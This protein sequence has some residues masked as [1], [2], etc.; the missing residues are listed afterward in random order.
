MDLRS[1][2][3]RL[4]HPAAHKTAAGW[5]PSRT[6]VFMRVFRASSGDVEKALRSMVAAR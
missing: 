6:W 4:D 2:A 3:F 5:V 1:A